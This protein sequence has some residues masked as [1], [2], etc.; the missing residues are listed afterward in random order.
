MPFTVVSLHAHPDDEAF[1]VGGTLARLA[2]EGHRVVLVV[3]TDGE[4]GLA[5][6]ELAG[7]DLGQRRRAEL[8]TAAARLGCAEVR[9]LGYADS[10]MDGRAEGNA[11]ARTPV[12]A[13]AQH[14]ASVLGELGADALT[15]YDSHGGYGHPD[16]IQVHRVGL[17]AA[18]LAGTPL[19]LEATVDRRPLIRVLKLLR[20]FRLSPAGWDPER[21]AG[22]YAD[23]GQITHRV[24]VAPWAEEKRAAM[25]AH[26][27]QATADTE[28]R[29]LAVFLRFPRPL[30]RLVFRHEWF[31][32]RSRPPVR[33]LVDDPLETLRDGRRTS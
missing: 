9:F 15:I 14:V 13:A 5:A 25:A 21:F 3:A 16:H 22:A 17:R 6:A 8:A 10:G 2:A 33:P 4:A 28:V 29:T 12:E 24:N 27:S 20:A 11:F 23:P 7:K 19:V 1:L 31:V 18:E 30:Y 32:E 26:A